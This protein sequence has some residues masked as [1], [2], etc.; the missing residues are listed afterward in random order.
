MTK[1]TTPLVGSGVAKRLAVHRHNGLFGC[2][3]MMQGQCTSI[4][5][6]ATTTDESREI[7]RDIYNLARKLAKSLKTRR[8]Q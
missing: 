3:R 8:E 4:L 1:S 2:A 7:A 6:T 5:S